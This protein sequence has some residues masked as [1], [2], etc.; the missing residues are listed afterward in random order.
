MTATVRERVEQLIQGVVLGGGGI[1]SGSS[2][3]SRS[4]TATTQAW[5]DDGVAPM[6]V[7]AGSDIYIVVEDRNALGEAYHRDSSNGSDGDAGNTPTDGMPVITLTID[8]LSRAGSAEATSDGRKALGQPATID[9]PFQDGSHVEILRHIP[10]QRIVDVFVL[11]R[12]NEAPSVAER[13]APFH[14]VVVT[15]LGTVTLFEVHTNSVGASPYNT[16]PLLSSPSSVKILAVWHA[17]AAI[18]G[19]RIQRIAV[20]PEAAENLKEHGGEQWNLVLWGRS[21]SCWIVRTSVSA[22]FD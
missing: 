7:A 1:G 10:H 8:T 18:V 4:V 2:A 15:S 14:V 6:A 5:D 20:D 12:E 22:S 16:K 19:A 17:G 11:T 3:K 21:N 13:I 9:A